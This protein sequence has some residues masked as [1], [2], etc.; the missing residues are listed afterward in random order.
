MG[1]FLTLVTLLMVGRMPT[2][3][4]DRK[5]TAGQALFLVAT[6]T[7]GLF[8]F[9]VDGAWF[10][11]LGIVLLI[12]AVVIAAEIY[13]LRNNKARMIGREVSF[14]VSLAAFSLY[15][16]PNSTLTFHQGRILSLTQFLNHYVLFF[17]LPDL[18]S[19]TETAL[20]LLVGTLFLV[21]EA[22]LVVRLVFEIFGFSPIAAMGTSPAQPRQLPRAAQVGPLE[23]EADYQAGRVI[24]ILERLF[25]YYAVLN[26]VYSI[27]GFITAAKA[28][29]RFKD[30]EKRPY[31]EYVL[32]GTLVSV[33]I[34]VLVSWLT[35]VALPS[36]PP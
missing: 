18:I 26:G 32:I 11:L 22:N 25:V 27:V 2:L 23:S 35:K 29:A 12:N 19:L 24:G 14:A 17:N 13:F 33:L 8:L 4:N 6:Q 28:F 7:G 36:F 5:M 3:Y 1:R 16:A 21:N 31:A 10:S 30:L 15:S 9:E 20:I 34:A